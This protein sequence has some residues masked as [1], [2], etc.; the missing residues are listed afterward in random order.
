MATLDAESLLR[1]QWHILLVLQWEILPELER[2]RDEK[3]M[4]VKNREYEKAAG[5]R[6]LERLLK[7]RLGMLQEAAL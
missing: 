2:L 6:N 1:L 7:M 5:V 4:I 3:N